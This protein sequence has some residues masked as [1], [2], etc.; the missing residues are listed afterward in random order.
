MAITSG[1]RP[2]DQ[3]NDTVLPTRTIPTFLRI[4]PETIRYVSAMVG[5]IDMAGIERCVIIADRRLFSTDNIDKL[6]KRH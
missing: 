4:I 2:D 1:I 6:K 3:Y 5:T